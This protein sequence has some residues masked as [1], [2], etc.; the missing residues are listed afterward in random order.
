V[1]ALLFEMSTNTS[2]P[3]I[4]GITPHLKDVTTPGSEVEIEG[5]I[6]F[7]GVVA[8]VAES[9]ILQYTG[10]LTTPPCSEGVTFLVVESPLKI[11][12]ADYNA[13]KKMVKFNSRLSQNVLDGDNILE[14][15]AKSVEMAKEA[16]AGRPPAGNATAEEPA[17][18]APAPSAA[19]PVAEAAAPVSGSTL[20][21]SELSG[22][23]MPTPVLGVVPKA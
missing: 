14:I 17:A 11:N 4:A 20:T 23:P 18:S 2:D 7:S 16:V 15:G 5:G 6:D 10:S 12:V 22:I 1:L 21:V 3:I 19:A 9:N 8:K 13:I